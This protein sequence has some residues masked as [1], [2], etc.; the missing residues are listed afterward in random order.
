M[1]YNMVSMLRTSK[2]KI[3]SFHTS[4]SHQLS[5]GYMMCTHCKLTK[6][7]SYKNILRL[8]MEAQREVTQLK[9]KGEKTFLLLEKLQ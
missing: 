1:N 7:H 5:V 3:S 6:E 8:V 4:W 2:K 9:T